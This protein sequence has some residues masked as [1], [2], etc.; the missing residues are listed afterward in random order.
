VVAGL[1]EAGY[2]V[3][4]PEA[5]FYLLPR[6]PIA[7][8]EKFV[9][10]LAEREVFTMPGSLLEVPGYFRI[11]LT[12]SDAMIDRALPVFAAL[13]AEVGSS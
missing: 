13:M 2:E 1:R 5:T 7:D 8:D 10:L 3:H 6:S 4:V 9:R 12:A 11:S